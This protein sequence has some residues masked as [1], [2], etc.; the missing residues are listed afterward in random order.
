VVGIA[1]GIATPLGSAVGIVNAGRPGTPPSADCGTIAVPPSGNETTAPVWPFGSFA[2][3]PVCFAPGGA[4]VAIGAAML[5]I[6]A[7]VAAV[8]SVAVS[9]GATLV[10][11]GAASVTSGWRSWEQAAT[12]KNGEIAAVAKIIRIARES[13]CGF[14]LFMAEHLTPREKGTL[15]F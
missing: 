12:H 11:S 14:A 13:S 9:A 2:V 6:A 10:A 3:F 4:T 15:V 1:V 5:A 7:A 8:V